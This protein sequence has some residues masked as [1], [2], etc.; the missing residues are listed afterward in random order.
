MSAV[1]GVLG[2][3]NAVHHAAADTKLE[4]TRDMAKQ[5]MAAAGPPW[6]SL[7]N[8]QPVSAERPLG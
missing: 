5:L 6:Q 8:D 4:P 2:G 7:L 1:N 3:T